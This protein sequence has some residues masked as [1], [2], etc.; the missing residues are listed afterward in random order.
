V[1]G[2][3]VWK[4]RAEVGNVNANDFNLARLRGDVRMRN[5]DCYRIAHVFCWRSKQEN[6]G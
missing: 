5:A 4:I 1:N 6:S 2:V 3:P